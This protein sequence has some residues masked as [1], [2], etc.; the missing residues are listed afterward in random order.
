MKRGTLQLEPNRQMPFK[1]LNNFKDRK[2]VGGQ[3][4]QKFLAGMHPVDALPCQQE[5]AV[6]SYAESP[7]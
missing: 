7:E 2:L 6:G 4:V 1:Y 5:P 3:L